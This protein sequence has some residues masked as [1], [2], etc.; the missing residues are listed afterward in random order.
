MI[1]NCRKM[2]KHVLKFILVTRRTK[3]D[4]HRFATRYHWVK[5]KKRRKKANLSPARVNQDSNLMKIV[6]RAIKVRTRS[7]LF[8]LTMT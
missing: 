6:S 1:T 2:A 5:R 7:N 4:V 8:I 3:A